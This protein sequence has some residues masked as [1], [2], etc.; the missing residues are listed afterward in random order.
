MVLE[1]WLS[2]G[3]IWGDVISDNDL[4][5]RSEASSDVPELNVEGEQPGLYPAIP[6][7]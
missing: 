4:D 5:E 7:T 3:Q 2:N 6:H 1:E